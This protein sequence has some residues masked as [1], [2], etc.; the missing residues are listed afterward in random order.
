M[1]AIEVRADNRIR[2]VHDEARDTEYCR[3]R[4]NGNEERHKGGRLTQD[5]ASNNSSQREKRLDQG[6]SKERLKYRKIR[7]MDGLAQR[8]ITVDKR[9]I[10]VLACSLLCWQILF[11][12]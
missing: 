6:K 12:S 4:G 5:W 11:W 7:G 10:G 3:R 1:G 8:R 9:C 2:R